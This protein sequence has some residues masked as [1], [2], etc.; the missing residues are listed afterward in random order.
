LSERSGSYE[1]SLEYFFLS[2][3]LVVSF[4]L[5][6][7]LFAFSTNFPPKKN[8]AN[9]EK[10]SAFECGFDPFSSPINTFDIHFYVVGLLFIIFDLELVFLYP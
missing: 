1:T 8:K 9:V 5:S 2:V 3:F 10:L 7:F 4:F 6:V